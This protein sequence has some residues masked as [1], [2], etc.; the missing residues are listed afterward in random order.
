MEQEITDEE[1][2]QF[3]YDNNL[4]FVDKWGEEDDIKGGSADLLKQLL[5]SIGYKITKQTI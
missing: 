3:M 2:Q 1:L 5:N 4:S